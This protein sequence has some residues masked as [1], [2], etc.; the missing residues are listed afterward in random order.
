MSALFLVWK[1]LLGL[2][3]PALCL[4][5]S[6]KYVLYTFTLFSVFTPTIFG[7]MYNARLLIGGKL[8]SVLDF[9]FILLLFVAY[10]L[11]RKRVKVP[12]FNRQDLSVFILT[13]LV[14]LNAIV[15]FYRLG[16]TGGVLNTTRLFMYLPVYF[17]AS[18]IFSNYK[19]TSDFYKYIQWFSL[20]VFVF[21][22]VTMFRIYVPP[23][24]EVALERYELEIYNQVVRPY[25]FFGEFFYIVSTSIT[26]C[27][28]KY[29]SG[30]KWFNYFVLSISVLGILFSQTRSLYG[31]LLLVFL[32]FF[33]FGK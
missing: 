28:L 10:P 16:T 17:A 4:V 33:I 15:G 14:V 13:V 32:G 30:K 29:G 2:L 23:M 22:V 19:D 21:H 3:S 25:M 8:W 31:S 18:K 5:P 11:A 7:F 26:L 27:A 9:Q 24:Y 6:R 20:L 12:A 1:G